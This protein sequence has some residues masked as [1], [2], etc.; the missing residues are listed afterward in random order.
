MALLRKKL[1]LILSTGS[2]RPNLWFF[3][4]LGALPWL[5]EKL[6]GPTSFSRPLHQQPARSV[7]SWPSELGARAHTEADMACDVVSER[8]GGAAARPFIARFRVL[9]VE[10]RS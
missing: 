1:G 10:L 7:A 8:K 9:G 5:L 2:I 3:G 4:D 6:G